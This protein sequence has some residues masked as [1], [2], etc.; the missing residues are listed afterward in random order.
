[1]VATSSATGFG[2]E[3]DEAVA[4]AAE[5]RQ[6]EESEGG[7][8][9]Q[10]SAASGGVAGPSASSRRRM[11]R[12]VELKRP[13]RSDSTASKGTTSGS[14]H[15][16]GAWSTTPSAS[17]SGARGGTQRVQGTPS[18]AAPPNPQASQ[19]AD[20]GGQPSTPSFAL[21]GQFQSTPQPTPHQGTPSFV[22][23]PNAQSTQ[24]QPSPPSF[25]IPPKAQSTFLAPRF[26]APTQPE[27]PEH[28]Q[29]PLASQLFQMPPPPPRPLFMPSSQLSQA[30]VLEE[31][32]LGDLEH[33]T[34][35][36]LD[37]LFGDEKEEEVPGTPE[38]G[39]QEMIGLEEY[40]HESEFDASESQVV[41]TQG[42]TVA[43]L[44]DKVCIRERS[45]AVHIL[46]TALLGVQTTIRG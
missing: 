32:G 12:V 31:A 8:M 33:M 16:A 6:R 20:A 9:A 36:E 40:F 25:D 42:A 24:R 44:G 5:K 18:F 21:G 35:K 28:S 3:F 23:P 39:D 41:G 4:A 27:Q 14:A 46:I 19:T 11:T 7:G 10:S 22:V 15:G 34:Q 13:T 38:Q 29:R 2:P 1:M 45:S 37:D 30:Q 17:G 26:Q 43:R